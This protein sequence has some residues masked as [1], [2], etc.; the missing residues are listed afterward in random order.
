MFENFFSKYL[1][2]KY[3]TFTLV[4]LL[5]LFFIFNC[6]DIAIMFFACFVIACSLNPIVDKLSKKLPRGI[7]T[8][9]VTAG[10][11]IL[12]LLIFIP[13]CI[14][15]FEQISMFVDKL[16]K[17]IDNFDEFVFNIPLL[18][19]FHFLAKDADSLM[20]QLSISS[21]DLITHAVDIGKCIGKSCM[22][23]IVSVIIIFNLVSDKNNI[24]KYYLSMFPSNI[25]DEAREISKIIADKM[26][27]YLIA[28]LASSSSVGI[29]MFIGLS[30]LH[31]PY[32]LLL[33]LITAIL[34]IIPVVGPALAIIIS[35]IA[36]Y[37]SG[38]TVI[39]SVIGVFIL[40]QIVENNLVRPY[41]FSKVMKIHPIVIFLFLFI[42]AEYIGFVGVIF[43]PALAALV[44]VLFEELYLKKIV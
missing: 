14:L 35:L 34:D 37:E 15:S 8:D 6:K 29:V 16:P 9:I 31:V 42:A 1:N 17:Y 40:A 39:L 36:V 11:L 22:Y 28:M 26:G 24:K 44:A 20:E 33:A 3:I 30:I 10:I 32:A 43:A 5:L 18:K 13:I 2:F 7:A 38:T 19:S 23:L 21:S 12:M 27:G 25:R 4:V 41:I